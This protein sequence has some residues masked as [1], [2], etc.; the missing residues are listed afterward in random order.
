MTTLIF[1]GLFDTWSAIPTSVW[2]IA[3][4]NLFFNVVLG[5]LNVVQ[6]RQGQKVQAAKEETSHWKGTAEAYEK[7]LK[8]VRERADREAGEKAKLQEEVTK[9]HERTDLKPLQEQMITLQGQL[10]ESMNK[11]SELFNMALAENTKMLKQLSEHICTHSSNEEAAFKS[12]ASAMTAIEQQ[13]LLNGR[14]QP[15]RSRVKK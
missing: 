12:L 6:F 9:L 4:I 5:T 15:R 1:L 7:E 3:G 8:V 2:F 10:V 13:V 11:Q 14:A